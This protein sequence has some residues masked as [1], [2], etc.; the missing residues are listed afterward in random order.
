MKSAGLFVWVASVALASGV[1]LGACG[2]GAEGVQGPKTPD[3]PAA[4]AASSAAT[5]AAVADAGAAATP[6]K[7]PEPTAEDGPCKV[8]GA[9]RK[10]EVDRIKAISESKDPLGRADAVSDEV[11]GAFVKCTKTKKG[12]AWGLALREVKSERNGITGVAVAVYVDPSGKKSEIKL[13]GPN[14]LSER[15]FSATDLDRVT[16]ATELGFDYD[17]DGEE[18]YVAVGSDQTKEGVKD[19][20]TWVVTVK[21]GAAQLYAPAK[22]IVAARVEDV[23]RDGR[24]DFVSYGPFRSRV[25]ARCNGEPTIAQGPS[26]LVHSLKD[27]AFSWTDEQAVA[28]AKQSCPKAGFE[29]ARDEEKK[30]DDE[31][32]FENVACAKLWGVPEAQIAGVISSQ[33]NPISGEAACKEA[34]L[35]SCG[36]TP[37]LLS[38]TKLTPPL[39]L[40]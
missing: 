29:I 16:I 6:K 4:S 26:L 19:L 9:E 23:D 17:G 7:D 22:D 35:K 32:T 3:G 30:V 31:Q 28:F 40:K 13:K 34:A 21:G 24:P 20:I 27:G 8:L 37:S 5:T 10:A 11:R 2:G 33:C 36:Q 38:W 1:A 15:S 39:K 12:G 25:P 18:E 14:R